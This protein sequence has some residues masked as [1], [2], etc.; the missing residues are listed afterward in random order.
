MK[1]FL[2]LFITT[3]AFGQATDSGYELPKPLP[4][5]GPTPP[6]V[7][8]PGGSFAPTAYNDTRPGMYDVFIWGGHRSVGTLAE[9]NAAKWKKEG[10]TIYVAETQKIYRLNS[11]MTWVDSN[12]SSDILYLKDFG[13]IG[14]GVA[15][16]TAAVQAAI[17]AAGGRILD[18][19]KGLYSVGPISIN[20]SCSIIGHHVYGNSGSATPATAAQYSGF[21][22]KTGASGALFTVD[23]AVVGEM[24][25]VYISGNSIAGGSNEG[26]VV[27][28]STS[29]GGYV[30][31]HVVLTDHGQSGLST[32]RS[33]TQVK[34]VTTR[35]CAIGIANFGGYNSIFED[36]DIAACSNMG[37]FVN[38]PARYT[39]FSNINIQQVGGQGIL[40]QGSQVFVN[41]GVI[42]ETGK[43]AI[44]FGL[45]THS[46]S[47][48]LVQDLITRN[49]N[50]QT[51]PLLTSYTPAAEGTY[52][53]ILISANDFK[54]SHI[55]F[56]RCSLN[57]AHPDSTTQT[58][59]GNRKVSYV[60]DYTQTI[61]VSTAR[62]TY[63]DCYFASDRAVNGAYP[64]WVP[65]QFT[66][67]NSSASGQTA[68]VHYFGTAAT[69]GD[70]ITVLRGIGTSPTAG[71]YPLVWN[72]TTKTVSA[73]PVDYAESG[74]WRPMPT[75]RVKYYAYETLPTAL[76]GVT[77]G[78]HDWSFS[79]TGSPTGT[80]ASSPNSPGHPS[81]IRLSTSTATPSAAN[82]S[83]RSDMFSLEPNER[84]TY[85]IMFRIPTLSTA[86]DRFIFQA[87][88]SDLTGAQSTD[89]I[90]IS[91]TDDPANGNGNFRLKTTANSVPSH[92]DAAVPALVNQ[93]YGASLTATTA[94]ANMSVNGVAFPSVTT[95]IPTGTS[96]SFGIVEKI[97][98]G[99]AITA[100]RSVD[101]DWFEVIIED[102]TQAW[103]PISNLQFFENME[104]PWHKLVAFQIK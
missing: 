91:Y 87:G 30:I 16:D 77:V 2:L 71:D 44:Q 79:G 32:S 10:M 89:G 86:T 75:A 62:N 94:A 60:V 55:Q 66:L 84:Y 43:A 33:K 50:C 3:L 27:N 17:A 104:M 38:T 67:V 18:I 92:G 39:H 29:G 81:A 25:Y 58:T 100:A 96:R 7:I 54:V 52:S 98:A 63:V 59:F 14:D 90:E 1:K 46:V 35:R 41:G 37:F 56:N 99:S 23:A 51:I 69:L 80:Q 11:A 28:E 88:F 9:R 61:P 5:T 64:S 47:N 53:A 82:W 48:I 103:V 22:R 74:T 34:S 6:T 76:I 72:A 49:A 65:E 13:A 19:G 8:K 36:I 101:I 102:T 73:N 93:W 31:D 68:Q 85:N 15:D 97:Y 45:G 78:T 40:I 70:A 95:T 20:T 12:P 26:L 83:A 24:H 21:I 42:G 4:D 57:V